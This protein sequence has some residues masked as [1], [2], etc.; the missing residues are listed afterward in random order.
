MWDGSET[1]NAIV[2]PG[3]EA[4]RYARLE[5][6]SFAIRSADMKWRARF[7]LWEH[8]EEDPYKISFHNL[9]IEDGGEAIELKHHEDGFLW[10]EPG[11]HVTHTAGGGHRFE[12]RD[13]SHLDKFAVEI[14]ALDPE[15]REEF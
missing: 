5:G 6:T 7:S 8:E 1:L 4:G 3:G 15:E 10:I 9:M 13:G 14:H 2:E 11:D 12:V